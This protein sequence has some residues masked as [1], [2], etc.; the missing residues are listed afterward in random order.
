MEHLVILEK[1]GF[2]LNRIHTLS[3]IMCIP[4][5]V[6]GLIQVLP[7]SVESTMK[8]YGIWHEAM[9]MQSHVPKGLMINVVQICRSCMISHMVACL[10]M[11]HMVARLHMVQLA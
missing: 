6:G 4:D 5:C 3:A 9:D 10:H 8:Q 2:Q 7:T 11:V 1:G